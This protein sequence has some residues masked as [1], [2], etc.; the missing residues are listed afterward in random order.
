MS[1][2]DLALIDGDPWNAAAVDAVE[3]AINAQCPAGTIR[4]TINASADTGWLLLNQTVSN[5]QTLYPV[6]WGIAPAAWK[7]GSS[8]V[9]PNVTDRTLLGSGTTA[10][11]AVGGANTKTIG[12]NN[13]PTHTHPIDP[14]NTAVT[15]TDP[16]HN[17]TIPS[18]LSG[19][20]SGFQVAGTG[21]V[22]TGTSSDTTGIT[23]SVDIA[24]FSSGNNTT[25]ATALDV[26]NA[27]L[28]VTWQ[29]RAY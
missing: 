10:L 6:L 19:A 16:G 22:Q 12:A 7:S 27:H 18:T 20:S 29:I 5:A 11:G 26:T 15:I 13:L 14:P 24:S 17:H 25:T 1:A 9:L 2:F 23:A 3:A 21:G 28:A 4:A 8:L